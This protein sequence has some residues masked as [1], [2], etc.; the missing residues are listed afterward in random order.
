MKKKKIFKFLRFLIL[1]TIYG[2][3]LS[4]PF[5]GNIDSKFLMVSLIATC[6]VFSL[7]MTA[8]AVYFFKT[9]LFMATFS[10]FLGSIVEIVSVCVR[11]MRL[12]PPMVH[13]GIFL[14]YLLGLY[15]SAILLFTFSVAITAISKSRG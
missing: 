9:D 8:R 1:P 3:C 15:L 14:I 10:V 11:I 6:V 2:V 7:F 4:I 13:V 5:W 12:G